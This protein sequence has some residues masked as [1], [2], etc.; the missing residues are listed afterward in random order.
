MRVCTEQRR[1]LLQL[2]DRLLDDIGVSRE[3]AMQEGGK[4]FWMLSAAGR[5]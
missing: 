2:D 4:R 1:A 3:Q 5:C